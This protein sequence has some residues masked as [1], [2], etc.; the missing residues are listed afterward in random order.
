M[1]RRIPNPIS[2]ARM[3]DPPALIKGRGIPVRGKILVIAPIFR[4]ACDTIQI[5]IPIDVS[6][7]KSSLEL[8]AILIP[9][10]RRARKREIRKIAPINPNSSEMTEN[11][12]SDAGLGKKP[13]FCLPSPNPTPFNPP[14]PIAI[15]DCL[16][17]YPFPS[18]SRSGCKNTEILF[19]LYGANL[20]NRI[21][22]DPKSP[23]INILCHK[24]VFATK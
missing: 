4:N 8:L 24:G 20:E 17:W 12:A 18:G 16:I 9:S 2:S 22:A 13:N 11:I 19:I 15:K 3:A 6:L 14:D 1:F 10:I 5:V 7:L 21:N 23:H